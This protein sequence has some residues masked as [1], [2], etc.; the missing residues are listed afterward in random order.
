[1]ETESYSHLPGDKVWIPQRQRK[2]EKH[3]EVAP[4]SYSVESG[5]RQYD[6][7]CLPK[8][9]SG[10]TPLDPGEQINAKPG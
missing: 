6:L 2:E 8:S 5:G 10:A 7:M 9:E 1:M 4:Q 3:G